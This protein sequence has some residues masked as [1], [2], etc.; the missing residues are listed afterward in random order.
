M[1]GLKEKK[2]KEPMGKFSKK[3]KKKIIKCLAF[4]WALN[5]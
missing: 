1:L 5:T 2:F 3:N 4:R